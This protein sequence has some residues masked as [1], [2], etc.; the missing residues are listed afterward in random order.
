MRQGDRSLCQLV[1]AGTAAFHTHSGRP[2]HQLLVWPIVTGSW[3]ESSI[4]LGHAQLRPTAGQ[5]LVLTFEHGVVC[6]RRSGNA[7]PTRPSLLMETHPVCGVDDEC[8]REALDGQE[9]PELAG[10]ADAIVED[11]A[12][13]QERLWTG[14]VRR[15][16]CTAR[17]QDSADAAMSVAA[18][19]WRAMSSSSPGT[20]VYLGPCEEQ[21][22]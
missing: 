17:R 10:E 21:V 16:A 18:R 13:D 1:G 7:P 12:V 4:G 9:Q 14:R 22:V 8:G 15:M 6:F 3:V 20:R 19:D 5:R 11:S 2:L